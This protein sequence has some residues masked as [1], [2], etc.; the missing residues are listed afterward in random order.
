MAY[1]SA[2]NNID[3]KNKSEDLSTPLGKTNLSKINTELRVHDERILELDM[4]RL[5]SEDISQVVKGVSVDNKTGVITITR[6]NGSVVTYDTVLEKIAVNFTFDESTK[7]LNI[8]L[9]DGTVVPVSLAAFIHETDYLESDTITPS[10]SNH[11]VKMEVKSNSIKAKHIDTDTLTNIKTDLNN[12][13]VSVE[14][15]TKTR[16]DDI[17]N[18]AINRVKEKADQAIS[19]IPEDYTSL[20]NSLTSLGLS[21]KN[22]IIIDTWEEN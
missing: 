3:W 22:G 18:Q 12:Y 19:S 7:T 14:N 11:K 8:K 9:S 2:H 6:W 15:N 16:I 10:V 5:K 20:S 17:A 21:V 1:S 13:A 4:S